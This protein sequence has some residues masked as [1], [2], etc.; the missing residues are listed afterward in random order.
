MGIVSGGELQ[1]RSSSN[2][3]WALDTARV[4]WHRVRVVNSRGDEIHH[5]LGPMGCM[6]HMSCCVD[7]AKGL[8]AICGGHGQSPSDALPLDCT[9][10]RL[11]QPGEGFACNVVKW[12]VDSQPEASGGSIGTASRLRR[13]AALFHLPSG[14]L[15]LFGGNNGELTVR[16]GDGYHQCSCEQVLVADTVGKAVGDVGSWR[17]ASKGAPADTVFPN[18]V[19]MLR[20]SSRLV[21]MDNLEASV[22]VHVLVLDAAADKSGNGANSCGSTSH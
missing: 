3:L 1:D 15:A 8:V 18:A 11:Y 4:A 13:D 14:H 7:A 16:F 12:P 2:E 20:S 19:A 6:R 5:A 10:L 17:P 21:V 9:L 22:R